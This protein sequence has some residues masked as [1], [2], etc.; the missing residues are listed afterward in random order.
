MGQ[1]HLEAG[2]VIER[3]SKVLE[4]VSRTLGKLHF[5]ETSTG[6]RE[7]LT[8]AIF[9]NEL[10]TKRLRIL[11]AVSTPDQLI[12]E[13]TPGIEP[14]KSLA[15]L[16]TH[17][18]DGTMRRVKYIQYLKEQ[19]ITCGQTNLIRSA[20]QNLSKEIDD[21][22]GCPSASSIQQ[23]W[24]AYDKR[25]G[26]VFVI[27]NKN[28]YRRSTE[29]LDADSEDFLKRHIEELYLL[30]TQPT[31]TGAFSGYCTALKLENAERKKAELTPLR[32]CSYRTFMRRIE[33][34]PKQEVMVARLGREAARHYFHMVKGALPSRYPLDAVEIDHSPLNVYVIDDVSFLPL[35]RPWI[36]VLKDR[37]SSVVLGFY[38]TFRKTG[39]DSIFGAIKHSLHSHNYVR[40][41]YPDLEN[42]WNTFGLGAEYVSDRGLDFLSQRYRLAV[43]SLGARYSYCQV[44]TP[45]LKGSV[46]R[47]FRTLEQSFFEAMPGRTYSSLAERRDYDP[48]KDAVI[49][50]STFV[51]L[52]H[53][54]C[55][56][57]HNVAPNMRKQA[58]PLQLWFDGSQI[59]PPI[60]AKSIDQ[61]NIVLGEHHS[62]TL[63]H[64]GLRFEWLQYADDGLEEVMEQFGKKIKLDF[65]VSPDNL[66]HIQVK[67]PKTGGYFPVR[68]TRPDYAEGL[69]LYQ[70]RY[71]RKSDREVM[72][73]AS[74]VD[75]LIDTR[76]QLQA[77][78][79]EEMDAKK[80]RGNNHY[81][82]LAGI[83]SNRTLEGETQTILN[84]FAGQTVEAPQP[85]AIEV[86]FTEI[87]VYGWG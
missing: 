69:T 37:Y 56:D 35:G 7:T 86:P 27:V 29:R 23:W 64:E 62:G 34:M 13:E 74:T 84:P 73:S 66:G 65:V 55:V 25:K 76:A 19:G 16:P 6:D 75:T 79:R 49:R 51:Y 58:T 43:T 1:F 14:L 2:L 30:P 52:M 87:K 83:N 22:K 68:C 21:P 42:D 10:Y 60:Y 40:S 20:A 46:E 72:K 80:V 39:L 3:Q 44:R 70:H 32:L 12:Y 26:D 61:L 54:W 9:W 50:F 38:I 18:Q 78:I 85:I 4:L 53:K 59:A 82:R 71:I 57:F 47:F 8:D 28:A 5:E 41:M 15:D 45:W 36:T 33:R 17:H 67:H 11:D 81:A 31:G 77:T 24:R 48:Q 63:S